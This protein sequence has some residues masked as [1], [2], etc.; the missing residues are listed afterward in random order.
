MVK[1]R[2]RSPEAVGAGVG[3]QA[4]VLERLEFAYESMGDV[5]SRDPLGLQ[6]G[7][8]DVTSTTLSGSR[9]AIPTPSK[10]GGKAGACMFYSVFSPTFNRLCV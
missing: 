2:A 5:E 3:A 8:E 6:E 10:T 9:Q 7:H 1:R 4:S